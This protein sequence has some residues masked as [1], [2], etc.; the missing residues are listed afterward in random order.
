[1]LAAEARKRASDLAN[2]V[3][4]AFRMPPYL[5]CLRVEDRRN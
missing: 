5:A 4:K 2:C 1:M 3:I